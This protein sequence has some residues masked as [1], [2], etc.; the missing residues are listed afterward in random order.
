MFWTNKFGLTWTQIGLNSNICLY[1]EAI[2]IDL[3]TDKEKERER[4]EREREKER[5]SG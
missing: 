5:P 2:F 1:I 3:Q 4:K